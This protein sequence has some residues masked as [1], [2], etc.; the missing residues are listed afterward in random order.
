MSPKLNNRLERAFY[1][2]LLLALASLG[3]GIAALT[4]LSL[5]SLALV[6]LLLLRKKEWLFSLADP[7]TLSYWFF[8]AVYLISVFYSCNEDSAWR[9]IETKMSFLIAA[10]ILRA[11][12]SRLS[13]AQLL[14]AFKTY[15]IGTAATL[16]FLVAYATYRSILAGSF[17]YPSPGGTY[18]LYFFLYESFSEAVMH[19][20][21]ISLYIGIAF[22]GTMFLG[23]EKHWSPTITFSLLGLFAIGLLL[24]QGRMTIIALALSL[25]LWLLLRI[26]KG[27]NWRSLLLF[28][29][30]GLIL[31]FGTIQ[32]APKSLSERYLAFPD[33]SY[34]IS[35]DDFNSATYRLAEWKCAWDGI[36]EA[37]ILGYG[38][39]CGQTELFKR[40]E[41]F[42]FWQ[43][44]ERQ[45][46]AHNQYLETWL[47]TGLL[48][49]IALISM[50]VSI[51]YLAVK[52]ANHFILYSLLFFA[53]C[54]ITES[55][56]ER[57]W[58]VV[59]FNLIFPLFIN[60]R[61]TSRD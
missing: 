15:I 60:L 25:G 39:G 27:A 50:M 33:F 20:G 14:K 52:K 21:Y 4:N 2:L 18:K 57:A 23:K 35:G 56:L 47:S 51:T 3:F 34:D 9:N 16:I 40:Y 10:P 53:L 41:K 42:Q 55:M 5:I 32:F 12:Q 36:T 17:S 37:P 19:P 26:S 49:L 24:L 29:T 7:I 8:F 6:G 58:A 48:G 44:L 61:L 28:A 22:I 30:L 1:S 54:L 13:Q 43:G 31:I 59:L 45:Y 46:N 38:V 11:Y